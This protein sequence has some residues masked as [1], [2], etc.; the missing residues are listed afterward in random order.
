[1]ILFLMVFF[2]FFKYRV[3]SKNFSAKWFLRLHFWFD[4]P[5]IIHLS[6]AAERNSRSLIF[7]KKVKKIV[8]CSRRFIQ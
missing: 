3:F 7:K 8:M 1:L 6:S 5:P 4:H 2:N